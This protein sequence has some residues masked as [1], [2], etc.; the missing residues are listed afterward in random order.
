M[1]GLELTLKEGDT[2]PEFSAET[3]GGNHI[4]LAELKGKYIVLYFYP[5]DDTPGCTKEACGFRD[6]WEELQ[7][8]GA[9]VLGVSTDSVKKHDKFV[10]K[11]SLPFPLLADENQS[12]V[13]DYGVWGLKKFM[14]RE[15]MGTHRI[16]FLINPE[17]NIEKIWP[18]VKPDQHAQEVLEAIQG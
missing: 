17:G 4:T 8:S 14:G 18:K 6:A 5:R 1:P 2:A 15:F 11:F 9:V 12:I 7:N 10:K 13:T 3:D 16:T